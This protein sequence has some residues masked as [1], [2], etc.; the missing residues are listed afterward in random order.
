MTK[1]LLQASSLFGGVA[2]AVTSAAASICCIGPLAIALLG[3]NGAILVAAFKSYRFYLL[4]A[5]VVLLAAAFWSVYGGRR[6]RD[7]LA[8]PVRAG[9]WTKAHRGRM[10]MGCPWYNGAE[11]EGH[12]RQR[13]TRWA[14]RCP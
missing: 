10:G 13:R 11:S 1:R 7:G 9:R 6:V 2:A 3:V 5:S 4:G 8:C 12:V 14:R